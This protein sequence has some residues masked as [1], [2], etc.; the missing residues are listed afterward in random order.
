MLS[1]KSFVGTNLRV[2][3][4]YAGSSLVVFTDN[5]TLGTSCKPCEDFN[6]LIT[7]REFKVQHGKWWEANMLRIGQVS[8]NQRAGDAQH[9]RLTL[10]HLCAR[11]GLG[12][13]VAAPDDPPGLPHMIWFKGFKNKGTVLDGERITLASLRA[14]VAAQEMSKED[15]EEL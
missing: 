5:V 9:V 14:W 10:T 8:C 11:F 12:N 4:G 6:T 3:S 13:G 15:V 1:T 2:S 7:S